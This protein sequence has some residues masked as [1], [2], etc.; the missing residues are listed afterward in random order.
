[1]TAGCEDSSPGDRPAAAARDS[2]GVTSVE[3]AVEVVEAAP[4]GSLAPELDVEHLRLVSTIGQLQGPESVTFGEILD[5]EVDREGRIY[6]MDDIVRRYGPEGTLTGR[7]ASQGEGPG[8]IR[9]P[10]DVELDVRGRLHVLDPRNGR[11]SIFETGP[12]ELRFA[13][14]ARLG[15]SMWRFCELDGDRWFARPIEG[16]LIHRL[17]PGGELAESFGEALPFPGEETLDETWRELARF[18]AN[19]GPILCLDDRGLV[20]LAAGSLPYLR[21]FDTAGS[22]RWRDTLDDYHP[23]RWVQDGPRMKGGPDG[24]DGHHFAQSLV[25]WSDDILLLQL[26]RRFPDREHPDRRFWALESRFISLTERRQVARSDSLPW[27]HAV[28]GDTVYAVRHL[29][30]PR[31]EIYER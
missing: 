7:I 29:P 12:R 6:V 31:V 10:L 28:R 4:A 9:N 24:E 26:E 1:M 14:A 19:A 15:R 2:A 16:S 11:I 8:E 27:I 13:G 5:L 18:Q 23:T 17:D 3:N 21:V 20:V 22:E 25:R 30:Y